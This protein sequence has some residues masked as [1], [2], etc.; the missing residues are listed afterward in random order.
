MPQEWCETAFQREG[1]LY[2]LR[3]SFGRGVAFECQDLLQSMPR[4]PFDVVLCRNVV[5]TYFSDDRRR[6]LLPRLCEVLKPGGALVIGIR[7]HLPADIG[8]L[9]PWFPELGI[10]RSAGGPDF[11]RTAPIPEVDARR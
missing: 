9:I 10:F 11:S 7:E 8:G 6:A 4:G 3:D 2:R 1:Q 5:F